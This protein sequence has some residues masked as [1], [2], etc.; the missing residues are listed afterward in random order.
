MELAMEPI[1]YL[2]RYSDWERMNHWALVILFFCA[3]LSGLSLFHPSLFFLSTL[4][5]GGPWTRILH[6][7]AGVLVFLSFGGMYLRLA[8]Y[9]AW[10]A[11]DSAWLARSGALFAGRTQEMP[12]VG[13]YNAGQKIVFWWIAVCVLVLLVTGLVFWRPYFVGYFPIGLVRAATL[14]HSLTAVVLILGVIGHVYA[15]I[16][17]KGTTRA[18][19]RGLVSESWAKHHHPRWYAQMTRDKR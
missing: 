13:R 6:P 12:P 9:N 18:M 14:L 16:W 11:D 5:G 3:A 15:A 1:R 17:V 2:Q 7:F 10:D 19:T 8:R 4:F